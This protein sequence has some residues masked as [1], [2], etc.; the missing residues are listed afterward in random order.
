MTKKIKKGDPVKI[1]ARW[2]DKG[3]DQFNW[4]AYADQ[5]GDRVQVTYDTYLPFRQVQTVLV[6]WLET[7]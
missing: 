5:T 7:K 2:Q 3:D 6:D 1:K 4:Y